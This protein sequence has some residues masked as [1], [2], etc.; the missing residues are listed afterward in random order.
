MAFLADNFTKSAKQFRD[1]LKR[2]NLK[3]YRRGTDTSNS[4]FNKLSTG[5][6]SDR[7]ACVVEPSRFKNRSLEGYNAL[8]TIPSNET[9]MEPPEEDEPHQPTTE[10]SMVKK[11]LRSGVTVYSSLPISLLHANNASRHVHT[12]MVSAHKYMAGSF[13]HEVSWQGV[14]QGLLV[15]G[16]EHPFIQDIFQRAVLSYVKYPD[17]MAAFG[18]MVRQGFCT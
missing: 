12:V 3:K 4:R 17:D 16:Y 9:R 10:T 15:G 7:K 8:S 14:N 1:R 2:W 13:E 5:S 11:P 18:R 6:N